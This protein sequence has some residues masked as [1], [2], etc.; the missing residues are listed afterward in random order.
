MASGF[1]PSP[2]SA[3]PEGLIAIGGDL[4][5]K[6]LLDAYR[7]GIFPWPIYDDQPMLWWSPDPRAI[8]PLDSLHVS[9]RLR[10]KLDSGI[11]IPT[12]NQ[13]FDEVIV[14]CS[15]GP[16]REDGTWLTTEMINAYQQFHQLGH[17]HSL[18]IWVDGKLAGGTYGVATGGL[19]AAESM[20]HRV[21]DASKA[22]VYYLVEHLTARGY[23]LLDIQQ[24]TPHTGRLGARE[25]SRFSYLKR[26]AAVVNQPITFGETIASTTATKR[27]EVAKR[28]N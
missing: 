26:L 14:A 23:G 24:W 6:R 4:S 15:E 1:F 2:E 11:F 9:R 7:H 5:A 21:T 18:E 12:I 13:A 22:A 16:G 25:I 3:G 20:F 28:D 17:A 27:S 10:R 19:F 8:L